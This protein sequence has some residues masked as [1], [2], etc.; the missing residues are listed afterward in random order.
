MPVEPAVGSLYGQQK[1]PESHDHREGELE[2][3]VRASLSLPLSLPEKELKCSPNY[4]QK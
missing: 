4:G 1:P 3:G 2:K